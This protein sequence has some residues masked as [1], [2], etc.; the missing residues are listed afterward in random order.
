VQRDEREGHDTMSKREMPPQRHAPTCDWWTD[1]YPWECTCG[2]IR[3][4][5]RASKTDKEQAQP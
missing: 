5:A 1:Q 3:T 2:A 4:A